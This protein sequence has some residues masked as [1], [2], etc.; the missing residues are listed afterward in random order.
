MKKILI[1]MLAIPWV[2]A[3]EGGSFNN[4][5]PNIPNYT[6]NLQINLSL[7]AYSSL[8]FASNHIIASSVGA[9]GVV[10]FNSGSGYLAY[11]LA[12]PNTSF[13][14]CLSAM[15]INGIEAECPCDDT[16]YNLFSGQSAGEE[17]PMKQYRVDV[18]GSI[19]TVSN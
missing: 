1:V 9:R 5:N 18:N 10:V 14:N 15:T 4:S 16:T 19:L 11:D 7:P 8:Q 2:M 3:C 12:C 6:F 13:A 17:Y